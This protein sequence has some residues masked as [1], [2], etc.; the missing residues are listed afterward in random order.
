MAP[1]DAAHLM[2]GVL[3]SEKEKMVM[4]GLMESWQRTSSA[5]VLLLAWR[6]PL[7]RA[8]NTISTTVS[9]C[10]HHPCAACIPHLRGWWLNRYTG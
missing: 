4:P 10:S 6:N 2:T 7:G 8:V 3:L 9:T 5:R 1:D